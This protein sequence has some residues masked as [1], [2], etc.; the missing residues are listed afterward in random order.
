MTARRAAR[1]EVTLGLVAL[2]LIAGAGVGLAVRRNTPVEPGL[3]V[4]PA[5]LDFGTVWEQPAYRHTFVVTNPTDRPIEVMEI[6]AGCD[7]TEVTPKA[8][9]LRPR[10]EQ[11]IALTLNLSKYVG[12]QA[13]RPF[14]TK[15]LLLTSLLPAGRAVEWAVTGEV[16]ANPILISG[17]PVT[18]SD[19]P[20]IDFGDDPEFGQPPRSREMDVSL[21]EDSPFSTLRATCLGPAGAADLR[22][23]Q[24]R[25]W[26]LS[27]KSPTDAPP[28][29]F[30]FIVRLEA[31]DDG[32]AKPFQDIK[33][34]GRASGDL[35]AWPS[36]LNFG[37]VEVGSSSREYVTVASRSGTPFRVDHIDV[38]NDT[39]VTPSPDQVSD[40]SRTFLVERVVTSVG[41]RADQILFHLEA[42]NTRNPAAR[43][44]RRVPL[45]VKIWS[46]GIQPRVAD[47][48]MFVD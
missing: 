47:G 34:I 36:Q 35:A 42:N 16:K 37:A 6:K 29:A 31:A 45:P 38:P 8:F 24:R 44:A 15:L 13:S 7:C 21:A 28:G 17:G 22:P 1:V 27:V 39:R 48:R 25:R 2:A 40:G 46:C 18:A 26:E 33:V 11:E 41:S 19:K 43:N 20:L 14:G 4:A 30:E 3:V 32:G 10:G 5:D 9:T 12:R 23:L